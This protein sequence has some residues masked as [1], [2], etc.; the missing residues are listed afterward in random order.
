MKSYWKGNLLEVTKSGDLII[1][2]YF[3]LP[4]CFFDRFL[5]KFGDARFRGNN[6]EGNSVFGFV[7]SPEVLRKE[8]S[9]DLSDL[10]YA[11]VSEYPINPL[12][13]ADLGLVA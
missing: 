9:C 12:G 10:V 8:A 3:P 4:L 6:A 7:L 5:F 2:P 13:C 1:R 11:D